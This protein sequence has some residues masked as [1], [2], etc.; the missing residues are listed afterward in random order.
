MSQWESRI[1][2]RKVVDPSSLKANSA[3][4]RLHDFDQQ[5]AMEKILDA[6]GWVQDV[7]VNVNTNTIIDGHMRVEIAIQRDE[8][9]PVVYVNLTPEEE[10]LVLAT[11][12]RVGLMATTDDDALLSLLT[13]LSDEDLEIARYV[14][15]MFEDEEVPQAD[16]WNLDS[17]KD[18][19]Y[20]KETPDLSIEPVGGNSA[21]NGDGNGTSGDTGDGPV[22]LQSAP[23]PQPT[24]SERQFV[25][26]VTPESRDAIVTA[27]DLVHKWV[28]PTATAGDAIAR[29]VQEFTS[30]FRE[31]PPA[32]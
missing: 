17:L 11:F 5:V 4:W 14:S 32:G 12:D 28:D 15:I 7:I 26:L 19:A 9:V 24:A 22:K 23:A 8:R 27:I 18:T 25:F 31:G 1:V 2:D 13:R 20:L 29:A 3:N 6:V 21:Y 10:A 30:A 16:A